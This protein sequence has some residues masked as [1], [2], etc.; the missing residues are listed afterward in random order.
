MTRNKVLTL[1][2]IAGTSFGGVIS[3]T[4]WPQWRGPFSNGSS[5]EK[6]LPAKWTKTENMAWVCPLPGP[7]AATP[8]ISNGKV[9]I[10]STDEQNSDLLGLC[11][12][13]GSGKELWRK[14]LA[15]A[16]CK[17]PRNNMA[18][19][20]PA[21]DGKQVY[22]L[23]GSGDLA[24][25]DYE[26]KVLWS[27]NLQKEYGNISIKYGY[28]SSPLLYEGRLY[29]LIQRRHTAYRSPESTTLDSFLLAVDTRTGENIWKQPRKTDARD[30]SFDAYSSPITFDNNNRREIVTIGGDC[31][32]G[33]DPSDGRELW[34]F[35][36][37]PIKHD[38]W[39]QIPMPVP[40]EEFVYGV[41]SRGNGIFA[42]KAG[43]K[44]ILSQEHIAWTFDGPTPDSGTPLYYEGHLY[45]LDDMG[46]GLSCLEAK[47]GQL[48]WHNK[49]GGNA[50]WRASLTA[51]D[52]KIYCMNETGLVVILE[53]DPKK[54]KVI[55]SID[56]NEKPSH[57]S[58][59]IAGGHLFIR[60]GRNLY[61]VGK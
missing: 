21:A 47:T 13:A 54:F 38:N 28:S 41:R 4:D 25:L 20:S 32:I 60:T 57:A 56:F 36:Y 53:A 24:A 8:I 46:N 23:F 50:P 34:R 30:E 29:L 39:R 27:R 35:D 3:A 37:N 33:H 15:V 26:G 17:V 7:A 12:D 9:F 40:G 48:K 22:F 58:I 51:A 1:M 19:S 2:I 55:S 42:V 11:I 14:K 31:I 52:G 44:G 61:C 16:Y 10:S 6:G 18:S 45:V 43:G 5:D 59:A 49:L